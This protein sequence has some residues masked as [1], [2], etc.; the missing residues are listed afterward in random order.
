MPFFQADFFLTPD[1]CLKILF[2][3]K[4]GGSVTVE[5]MGLLSFV[6]VGKAGSNGDC[7]AAQEQEEE[8]EG[9]EVAGDHFGR[10]YK[11]GGGCRL[12]PCA[13]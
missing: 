2:L 8:E 11:T 4:G 9:D 10:A 3:L 5:A 6:E 1:Q 7:A 13:G 12:I